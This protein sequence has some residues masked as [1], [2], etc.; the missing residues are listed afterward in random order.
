MHLLQKVE[1]HRRTLSHPTSY[2]THYCTPQMY[3]LECILLVFS[4]PYPTFIPRLHIRCHTTLV[5][6]PSYPTC[7]PTTVPYLH[8][9]HHMPQACRTCIPP[10]YFTYFLSYPTCMSSTISHLCTN[11]CD[12]LYSL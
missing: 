7:L 2:H 11:R 12:H 6:P 1:S 9:H 5:H 4:P 3:P 8:T 10:L